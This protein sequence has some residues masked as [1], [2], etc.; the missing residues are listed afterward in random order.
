MGIS[1]STSNCIEYTILGVQTSFLLLEVLL[2]KDTLY[3]QRMSAD[4][5]DEWAE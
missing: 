2:P 5:A 3:W 1:E 4:V